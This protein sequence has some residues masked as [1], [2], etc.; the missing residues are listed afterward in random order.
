MSRDPYERSDRAQTPSKERSSNSNAPRRDAKYNRKKKKFKRRRRIFFGIIFSFIFLIGFLSVYIYSKTLG[1]I[2]VQG[3]NKDNASLGISQEVLDSI[4]EKDLGDSITNIALFGIDSRDINNTAGSRSDSI[5][6]A[7][8]DYKHKKLKMTSILRDSRVEIEGHGLDKITHAYAF[9]GPELAVKTLN[10]NFGLNIR[11]YVTINFFGLEDIID[12]LGGIT[13]EVKSNEV[14]EINKYIKE[15]CDID[16]KKYIPITKSGTQKLTGRQATSYARIRHVGNGDWE[17]T[18]RQRKVM[19][20]IFSEVMHA[21]VTKYGSLM[22]SMFPYVVTSIEKS[23]ML[24]MGTKFF[25][26]GIKNIEQARFPADGY[27]TDPTINGISYI[28]PKMPD[29]KNQI[30]AFIFDDV[31]SPNKGAQN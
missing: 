21:G 1:K 24:S 7:T 27:W 29:T 18:D 10:K 19:D 28:K 26:S 20:Q 30:E 13:L 23:T 17:R 25:T 8:I 2:N 12:G 22:S 5:M 15:L 4:K 6:I 14:N 3:I 16:H 31:A 9:G 11:D